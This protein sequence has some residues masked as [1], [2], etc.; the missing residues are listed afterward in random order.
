MTTVKDFTQGERTARR[1]GIFDAVWERAKTKVKSKADNNE[2]DCRYRDRKGN[3]CFAGVLIPDALYNPAIEGRRFSALLEEGIPC[4]VAACH[5]D[6]VDL[7]E[8]LQ[9]IHDLIPVEHWEGALRY[10]AM[11]NFLSVQD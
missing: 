1:Q 3:K 5:R 6:D 8:Q 4:A 7:V 11:I 10:F 2:F 9:R